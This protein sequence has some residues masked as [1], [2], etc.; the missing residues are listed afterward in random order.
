MSIV[1]QRMLSCCLNTCLETWWLHTNTHSQRKY[2]FPLSSASFMLHCLLSVLHLWHLSSLS[3]E[4]HSIHSLQEIRGDL[5]SISHAE[6]WFTFHEVWVYEWNPAN[7]RTNQKHEVL[8]KIQGFF[9]SAVDLSSFKCQGSFIEC[10]VLHTA[11]RSISGQIS[12]DALWHFHTFIF[13]K[14]TW[15]KI[16]IMFLGER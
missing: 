11:S 15:K 9:I 6:E 1:A 5:L 14:D 13:A 2:L 3:H 4:M 8:G 12:V 16:L 7:I 10:D